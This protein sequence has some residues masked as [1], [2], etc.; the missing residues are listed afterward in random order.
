MNPGPPNRR[1][2]NWAAAGLFA[3]TRERRMWYLVLAVIAAIFATLGFGGWLAG[4]LAAAGLLEAAAAFIFLAGMIL[5]AATVLIQGLNQRPSGLNL[6]IAVGAT[7]MLLML[8]LRTAVLAERSH[9]VEYAVLG[10]F[11]YAAL[12]E[13][14]AGGRRVPFAWL[15]ALVLTTLVGTLDELVQLFIPGRHFDPVDILFNFLAATFAIAG[16]AGIG[17]THRRIGRKSGP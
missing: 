13:R 11:V 6:V 2:A 5:V 9:L 10:A 12:A 7:A 3:S 1:F 17:W 14:V 8:F 4:E 16:R 15:W